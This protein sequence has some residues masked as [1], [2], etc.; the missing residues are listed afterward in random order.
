MGEAGIVSFGSTEK[1]GLLGGQ[2][3]GDIFKEKQGISGRAN[4]LCKGKQGPWRRFTLAGA[5]REPGVL[6]V[7]LGVAGR[8]RGG[9]E[10]RLKILASS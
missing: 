2:P 6:E 8:A 3:W 4:Q 1:D 5:C 9:P 7:R 10:S